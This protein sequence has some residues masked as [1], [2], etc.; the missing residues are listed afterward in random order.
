MIQ[1]YLLQ[2]LFIVASFLLFA[3]TVCA[4][5]R[6][7]LTETISMFWCFA[8]ILFF[9]GGILIF[10][11]DWH[12]YITTSA[13]I[14]MAVGFALVIEAMYWFSFQLSYNIR[15]TQELAIQISLLNQEHIKVDNCLSG[16]SGQ[17]R[18]Q[19]W[20]TTTVAE[21]VAAQCQEEEKNHE[22]CAV[23]H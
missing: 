20:R 5:A 10:F 15:K 13:V 2:V 14:V 9:I 22:E 11:V 4:L 16:V 18:N 12:E 19:I 17:T 1:E 3:R 23:C 21:D 8:A 7:K 6:K